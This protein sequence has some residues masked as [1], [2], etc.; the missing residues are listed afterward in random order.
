[1][2]NKTDI[3]T[4][5]PEFGVDSRY[6]SNLEKVAD[7]VALMQARLD[8]L[9]NLSKEQIIHAKLIQLKLKMEDYL[10]K[11]SI[12]GNRKTN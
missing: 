9:K 10:S 2:K 12:N 7:S 8:R 11:P 5:D 1:M 3:K 6:A 4:T